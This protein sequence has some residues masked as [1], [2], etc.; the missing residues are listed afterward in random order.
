MSLATIGDLYRLRAPGK[1]TPEVVS[2]PK[3]VLEVGVLFVGAPSLLPGEQRGLEGI[4]SPYASRL[5][6]TKLVTHF[7]NSKTGRPEAY[8]YF[9]ETMTF[10]EMNLLLGRTPALVGAGGWELRVMSKAGRISDVIVVP[11]YTARC[12]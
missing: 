7:I 9:C 3:T 2:P 8:V 10:D 11:Q 5:W 6:A 12:K 4:T 1:V